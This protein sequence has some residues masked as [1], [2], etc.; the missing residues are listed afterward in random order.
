MVAELERAAAR[1]RELA[2]GFIPPDFAHV[3]DPDAAIF[4]CAVDHRTGYERPH[5]VDGRGPFAGSEL[6]WELGLAAARRRPGWLTTAGL[7]EVS[8]TDIA[9]AFS[10]G[11]ETVA[12]PERR[13]ALWRDLA[14]GLLARYGGRAADL[15]A[16]SGG[17][18][19]GEQ[20]LLSRL[21]SFDAYSDPLAKKSFLFAKICERRSWL[22]VAD[23]ECWEVC[24]DNVLMRLA[25]R[26]GLVEPAGLDE[27]RA[28]TRAALKELAAEAGLPPPILDDLLWDRGRD[29][30]DLLGAE[31]GDLAEP[32]REPASA[33]Y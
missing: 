25:L 30:P 10:A 4:L 27:V 17:R 12:D 26:C 24:V 29:D 31:A 19:G 9:A 15:L 33:W 23:P 16:A 32:P 5:E 7:T 3:P 20:G 2:A 21:A 18:L 11:G 1:V 22:A 14:A 8:A 6:M 28:A 13:A